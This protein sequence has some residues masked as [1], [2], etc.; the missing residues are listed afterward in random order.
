MFTSLGGELP[1]PTRI[2]VMLSDILKVVAIPIVVV[3]VGLHRL[4]GQAQ[5]RPRPCARGSTRSSSRCRSSATCSRRSRSAR[6][7]RNFGTMIHAGV[8]ILQ[9]LDIVGE[10]S[11]N[12]VIEQRRQGRPGVGAVGAS[13]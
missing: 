5:E 8:P 4:V 2:L 6:F 11:G 7:T 1:L 9:A 10:T 13:P 3:L 12:L